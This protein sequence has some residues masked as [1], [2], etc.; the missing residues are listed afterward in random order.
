MLLKELIRL[1][2][3]MQV[4][5]IVNKK[6]SVLIY[7]SRCVNQCVSNYGDWLVKERGIK[8]S[9]NAVIEIKIIMND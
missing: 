1:L 3:P 2:H 8:T 6:G 9:L 5:R 4:V 7:K